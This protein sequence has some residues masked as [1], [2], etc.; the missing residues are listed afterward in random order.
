MFIQIRIM[1][2]YSL[3][4]GHVPKYHSHLTPSGDS[5]PGGVR[6]SFFINQSDR[7]WCYQSSVSAAFYFTMQLSWFWIC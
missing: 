4:V 7:S 6:C 5:S 2:E 3:W 1:V